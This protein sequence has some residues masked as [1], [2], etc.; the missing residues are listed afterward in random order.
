[1]F[2]TLVSSKIR[3]S[4]LEHILSH[5]DQRFYLRGIAKELTL[6]VSPVRRELKRLEQLGV[7]K[8]QQEANILFYLVDQ[9]S[10]QFAQLK[11]AA[12]GS[13]EPEGGPE[14]TPLVAAT[15]IT[16]PKIERIRRALRP[17]VPWPLVLGVTTVGVL[18]VAVVGLAVY[19]AMTNQRLLSLSGEAL[20]APRTQVTVVEAS[21]Q[22][23]GEMRSGRWRLLPGAVGGFS[24]GGATEETY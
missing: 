19:L 13:V 7:L 22:A 18:A 24:T 14:S 16:H 5:P 12:G 11:S 2:E 15:V 9:T 10:P 6:P 20:S 8:V 3:R 23:S 4:L 17:A 21:P 1:M